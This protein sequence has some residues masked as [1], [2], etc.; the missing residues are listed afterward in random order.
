MN[1]AKGEK[2]FLTISPIS[3]MSFGHGS[4][5]TPGVVGLQDLTVDLPVVR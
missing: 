3:D 4:I 1:V 5:R 2:L